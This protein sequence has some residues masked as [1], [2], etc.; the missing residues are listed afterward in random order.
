M[1]RPQKDGR[2]HLVEAHARGNDRAAPAL[3]NVAR[4]GEVVLH[5]HPSGVLRPSE[6]DLNV[7]SALGNLGV[8]FYIVDNLAQDVY[9]VVEPYQPQETHCLDEE[10]LVEDLSEAGSLAQNLDDFEVRP[11]QIAM[12]RAIASAFNDEGW[13]LVEAGTGTGKSFAYLFPAIRFA[14]EN[15]EKVVV[16]TN[17]INLQTQLIEKDIPEVAK[18][19]GEEVQATLLKGRSNY[20]CLRKLHDALS[21]ATLFE[22]QDPKRIELRKIG[23]WAEEDPEG[24]RQSLGFLPD[25]EVW[26]RIQSETDTTLR[27]KCPFYNRCFFYQSRRKAAGSDLVVVNHHLLLSDLELRRE[28]GQGVTA[29]LPPYRR[30]ILDEAHHLED[31]A[32][33]HLAETVTQDGLKKLLG[34]LLAGKKAGKGRIAALRTRLQGLVGKVS[35]ETVRRLQEPFLDEVLPSHRKLSQSLDLDFTALQEGLLEALPQRPQRGKWVKFRIQPEFE[36]GLFFQ[37]IMAVRI[38]GLVRRIQNYTL[39]VAAALKRLEDLPDDCLEMLSGPILD[40]RSQVRRLE[41]RAAILAAFLR[42]QEGVCRWVELGRS[43]QGRWVLR[44][45]RAPIEVGP[46]LKEVLFDPLATVAL[47]SA[48]LRSSKGFAYLLSRLGLPEGHP[49]LETLALASPFD[50]ATQTLLAVPRDLPP[51]NHPR[52]AQELSEV[53]FDSISM[54]GGRT[55]LLFTSYRLLEDVLRR[56]EDRLRFLG[57]TPLVQGRDDRHRLL[58]RFRHQPSSVLFAT[59]SFWEGVDVPGDALQL[60]VL[61]KLPFRVPDE[62]ILQARTERIQAQGGDPFRDYSVPQA[63]LRFRQGYGRLIRTKRDR[64]VVLVTDRRL[65]EKS[66]GKE[67]LREV[68]GESLRSGPWKEI[69]P[70][71]R[72]FFR[73]ES[74]VPDLRTVEL[75]PGSEDPWGC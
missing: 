43:R 8:G 21:E 7:A 56:L 48:T 45:A 68:P 10:G 35:L 44:I 42:N 53:V 61:T 37:E 70:K 20:V 19:L 31:V 49:R 17:T 57:C 50:Y 30:L 41:D 64:G 24:S 62:P 55:L 38:R 60:V 47:T 23:Q 69:E 58:E 6:A 34:R 22:D 33:H 11:Q 67:F 39:R 63:V 18:A 28:V 27:V 75:E 46:L 12:S 5:N 14:K 54:L 3:L 59:N 40:V 52:F 13:S 29:L 26:D 25:S 1:G 2:I 73:G 9:V 51:P 32:T 36:E 4:P 71:V 15:S 74:E 66:Y 16:S 72:A 65:V